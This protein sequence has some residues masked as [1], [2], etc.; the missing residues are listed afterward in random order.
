M[1]D[2]YRVSYIHFLSKISFMVKWTYSYLFPCDYLGPYQA[3]MIRPCICRSFID[4]IFAL[5][6]HLFIFIFFQLLLQFT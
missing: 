2:T 5:S 4:A 3:S 1:I 6:P